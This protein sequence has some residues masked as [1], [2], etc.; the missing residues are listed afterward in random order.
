M[1]MSQRH[2]HTTERDCPPD[3]PLPFIKFLI[4]TRRKLID[5][6]RKL[7]L[8]GSRLNVKRQKRLLLVVFLNKHIPCVYK[9]ITRYYLLVTILLQ[10]IIKRHW[11]YTSLW[12][13]NYRV[14]SLNYFNLKKNSVPITVRVVRE[15]TTV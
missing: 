13:L 7:L 4:I 3:N 5:E 6:N 8:S 9:S 10:Y 1:F 15:S 12:D 11:I 2:L 14:H